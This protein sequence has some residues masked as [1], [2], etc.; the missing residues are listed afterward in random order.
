MTKFLRRSSVLAVAAAALGV[1]GVG[2]ASPTMT[3]SSRLTPLSATFTNPPGGDLVSERVLGPVIIDVF[4]NVP[5]IYAG[6]L[7]GTAV[8]K[9]TIVNYADNSFDFWGVDDCPCTVAGRSGTFQLLFSG[10]GQPDGS[11]AGQ[12]I[13]LHGTGGLAGLFGYGTFS[14]PNSNGGSFSGSYLFTR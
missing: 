7:A 10:H 5:S 11:F 3:A 9:F 12:F 13:I 4:A 6:D 8:R 1:A 14:A 2:T